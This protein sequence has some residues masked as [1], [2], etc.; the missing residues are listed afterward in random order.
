[1]AAEISASLVLACLL[2]NLSN[3]HDPFKISRSFRKNQ[4]KSSGFAHSL[5]VLLTVALTLGYSL[6]R[7]QSERLTKSRMIAKF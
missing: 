1:M 6:E 5:F 7:E 4:T 3:K 2:D